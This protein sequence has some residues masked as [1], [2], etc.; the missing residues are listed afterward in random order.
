MSAGSILTA[1]ATLGS[2]TSE[3]SG[4]VTVV[5]PSTGV[6]VSG[7]VYEDANLNLQKDSAETGSGLTLFVKLVASATPAG[8]ALAAATVDLVTGAFTFNNVAPGT[9]TLILDDNNTLSDVTPALPNGWSGTEMGNGARTPV[10]VNT[11][12]LPNQ[13][14]GLYHGLLISGRVFNDNGVSGGVPND[15]VMNGGE[16]GI[17]G[18]ALRLTDA[19]GAT[20]YATANTDASGV[21]AL[22][23]PSTIAPGTP[24]KIS[25]TNANGFLSTGATVGNTVGS[26][27][28]ASDT[29]SF[30][31]LANTV[32]A[33]VNFGDVAPNTLST[34]GQQAGLP[35][36]TV[37]YP[38]TFKAASA[39]SVTFSAADAQTPAFP[40]W[41]STL[42]RDTNA[43]GQL[44][45]G[46]PAISA[47][48]AVTAGETIAV[49][50][51][52]FIPTNA[53]FGLTNTTTLTASFS[54]SGAA[55]PLAAT[56]TRTDITTV[57]NP[58][59]AGLKLT[60][61]VNKPSALPGET[62]TYTITYTNNSSELL[63]NVV[64]YDTTPAFT[65]FT[66]ATNGPLPLDL[67]GVVLTSPA[68]NADRRDEMDL[69]RNARS[70]RHRDCRVYGQAG[71]I[72]SRRLFPFRLAPACDFKK[73]MRPSTIRSRFASQS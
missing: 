48:L 65:K 21:Y 26:Y 53:A 33:N 67:T 6:D 66:S 28:R 54:Y 50:A 7:L 35:G 62:I 38:H 60:K 61:A 22:A 59:T 41:T 2:A 49:I 14:F 8:P 72:T 11:V 27:D 30:T 10:A 25:E 43:N 16:S 39:G 71:P 36:T 46:E 56:L 42:Y 73:A 70:W 51:K 32:Y 29:V 37:F 1:T 9:Y 18:V 24:L 31:V 17:A 58:T 4:N 12:A 68:P 57:G 69:R 45:A 52:I 19:S 34:D 55:P 13:N 63:R 5:I 64:I 47:P 20:V 3:F 44:D 23:L 40:G 15:G